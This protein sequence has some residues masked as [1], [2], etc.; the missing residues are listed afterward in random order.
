MREEVLLAEDLVHQRA[1]VVDLVVVDR[2]EDHAVFTQQV[3]RQEER[4]YIIE[5]HL[6]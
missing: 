4:G 6:E 1:Q 2:D 3:P 5:S